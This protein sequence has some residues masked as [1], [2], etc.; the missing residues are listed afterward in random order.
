MNPKQLML[1]HVVE[2]RKYVSNWPRLLTFRTFQ[3]SHKLGTKQLYLEKG[4]GYLLEN[5]ETAMFFAHVLKNKQIFNNIIHT[6]SVGGWPSTYP[7]VPLG[8]RLIAPFVPPSHHLAPTFVP[9]RHCLALFVPRFFEIGAVSRPH[10]ILIVR[11]CKSSNSVV[12]RWSLTWAILPI[13]RL[14]Q[15]YLSNCPKCPC[16]CPRDIL[17]DIFNYLMD[18]WT[19]P[20]TFVYNR[21][22]LWT[23][24]HL[25]GHSR[26]HLHGLFMDICMDNFMDI[27]MYIRSAVH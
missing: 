17:L 10:C 24:G 21:S 1:I 14:S 25:C 20:W 3:I 11:C 18:K 2:T 19:F 22:P 12:V 8:H 23:I 27:F 13:S 6:F 15:E 9:P 7:F 5:R 16:N 4:L 26:G